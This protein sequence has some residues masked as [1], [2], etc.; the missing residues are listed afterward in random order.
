[1][2]AAVPDVIRECVLR[3]A[4]SLLNDYSG[5]MSDA[6]RRAKDADALE[7]VATQLAHLTA[8]VEDAGRLD[9]LESLHPTTR[10]HFT[11]KSWWLPITGVRYQFGWELPDCA[12]LR[13]A[14][15]NARKEL[16]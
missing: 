6:D 10:R 14:I 5:T 4:S 7:Q 12:T 11:L 2:S 16:K 8:L 13:E 1:M 9:W 15:D 3:V